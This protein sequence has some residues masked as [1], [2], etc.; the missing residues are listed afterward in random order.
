MNVGPYTILIAIIQ[1]HF[2]RSSIDIKKR[3]IKT[4]IAVIDAVF[5][6]WQHN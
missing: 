5:D 3:G 1:S 2:L 4:T 6:L